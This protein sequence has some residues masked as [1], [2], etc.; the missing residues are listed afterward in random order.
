M[1]EK[2]VINIEELRRKLQC[3][4]ADHGV[5]DAPSGG[6]TITHEDPLKDKVRDVTETVML[7]LRSRGLA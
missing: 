2:Q 4:L 7:K 6:C 1:S 3:I 5:V